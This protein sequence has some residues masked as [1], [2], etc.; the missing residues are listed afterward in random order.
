MF[1][2]EKEGREGL[3]RMVPPITLL[4]FLKEVGFFCYYYSVAAIDAWQVFNTKD[5]SV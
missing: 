1:Q 5:P 3:K 2:Q 4:S